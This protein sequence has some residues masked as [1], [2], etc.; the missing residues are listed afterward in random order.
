[1]GEK[2][3]IESILGTTMTVEVAAV[4]QLA[5]YPAVIPQVSG[6]AFVTGRSEFVF[7]PQDPLRNGFLLR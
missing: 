5:D 4:T 7:D 1:V 2:I 6:T 3:T